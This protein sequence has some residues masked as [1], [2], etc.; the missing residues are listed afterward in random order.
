MRLQTFMSRLLIA[1]PLAIASACGGG[2]ASSGDTVTVG[3]LLPFTGP[4]SATTRNF[5]RAALYAADR[6]NAGGGIHG[7]RLR[8]VSRDTHDDVERSRQSTDDLIAEGAVV[9]VGPESAGIAE[10][11]APTLA[12]HQV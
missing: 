3:L 5:E 6:V 10:A 7:R 4:S 8:I 11:I 1:L 2:A 9:V 12:E